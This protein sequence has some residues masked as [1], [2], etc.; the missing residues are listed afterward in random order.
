[1]G[2][3]LAHKYWGKGLMT[4]AARALLAYAFESQDPHLIM[5]WCIAENKGSS[6]VMQK[7][8][9][10]FEGRLRGRVF[11]HGKQWDMDSYAILK[12]EWQRTKK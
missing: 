5:A 9:M 1:M 6:R 10:T 8:G 2:Y 7:L 12:E 3:A 11:R 4:E